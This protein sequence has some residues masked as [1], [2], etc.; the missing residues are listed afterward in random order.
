MSTAARLQGL[1]RNRLFWIGCILRLLLIGTAF[2]QTHE[3]WF[4]PFVENGVRGFAADPWTYHLEQGGSALAF[5]YGPVMYLYY[6]LFSLF[7]AF[8]GWLMG[9]QNSA[10]IAFGLA[11]FAC[12][13]ILLLLVASL[14]KETPEKLLGYLWLSP[15]AL[16]VCYWHGQ[17]DIVPVVLVTATLAALAATRPVL[18]GTALGAGVA[19][20]LSVLLAAPLI[21]VYLWRNLRW[22]YLLKP[23]AAAFLGTAGLL[24]AVS[25]LSPGFRTIALGSPEF[26]KAYSVGFSMGTGQTIFLLPLLYSLVLYGAWR[27]ERMSFE[28][29]FVFVGIAFFSVLLLTPASTGWYLWVLPFMAVMQFRAGPTTAL[30]GVA[31]SF[32]FVCTS[33]LFAT[34]ATLPIFGID[35]RGPFAE[36]LPMNR[37]FLHSLCLSATWVT[38]VLFCLQM[39]IHGIRKNDYFRLSRRP[40]TIGI[41]GDSGSGKDTLAGAISGLFGNEC[42]T[43]IC[44]DDYHKWDRTA[45]M[46]KVLTHLDPRAND[47]GK[48]TRDFLALLDGKKVLSRHYDH[49]SGKFR[50]AAA[51]AKNDVVVV[52]GLH[53]LFVNAIKSRLD[54]SIFLEMD[55]G[56]RRCFKVRRDVNERGRELEYVLASIDKRR[57]DSD[58]YI[59]PQAKAAD[60]VFSL[61]AA[62]PNDVDNSVALGRYRLEVLAKDGVYS[63]GIVHTLIGLCGMQVEA[64]AWDATGSVKLSIEGD[65]SEED[66]EL[67]AA[68][69]VP[70]M[71]ELM[72]RKPTWYGGMLGVMQ[73]ISLS[74]VYNSLQARLSYA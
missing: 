32:L 43:S 19:A 5:P 34:G 37:G 68:T 23:F 4:V 31:F 29:F 56:L 45:P 21:L 51:V 47:L 40:I 67:A 50:R 25:L 6:G 55:E 41:A 35:A 11:N 10:P 66:I 74:H 15:M 8:A 24:T 48:L 71:D 61:S 72:A 14:A 44:G 1:L 49:E 60:V 39:F 52:S 26:S 70:G 7:G 57:P 16:Y 30:L 2:P 27:L 3:A 62:D 36:L 69:I 53:V 73:L 42:V 13:V 9:L 59:G 46:W 38:G 22:R 54:L 58:R 20:K 17:L 63:E 12:E 64:T 18:A 33:L 65:I 28:L